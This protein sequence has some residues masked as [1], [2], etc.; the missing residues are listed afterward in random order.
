[1]N[2]KNTIGQTVIHRQHG[3]GV[4][5]EIEEYIKIDFKFKTSLFPLD[6]FEK[7]ILKFKD[8]NIQNELEKELNKEKIKDHI[9]NMY[10]DEDCSFYK[11]VELAE[12]FEENSD[13]ETANNL[14][15][16]FSLKGNYKAS[17][18]LAGK[19][20]E[21]KTV[22]YSLAKALDY[23]ELAYNQIIIYNEQDLYSSKYDVL[24]FSD[25]CANLYEMYYK[26]IG[27]KKN[28]DKAL[29]YYEELI[30]SEYGYRYYEEELEAIIEGKKISELE[31]QIKEG[32]ID[33]VVEL[34]NLYCIPRIIMLKDRPLSY[35]S[36]TKESLS[37]A[38]ELYEIAVNNNHPAAM[39]QLAR[40]Y[41]DGRYVEKDEEKAFELYKQA[42]EL[43]YINAYYFVGIGYEY[44][45]GTN[46][47]LNK[48]IEY[49]TIA[50]NKGYFY[51]TLQLATI[52]FEGE[53][54]KQDIEKAFQLIDSDVMHDKIN[55]AN[56]EDY[57][58]LKDR[59]REALNKKEEKDNPLDTAKELLDNAITYKQNETFINDRQKLNEAIEILEKLVLYNDLTAIELLSDIYYGTIT[60]TK[61]P[62]K[63][64]EL[65]NKYF[66]LDN[67]KKYKCIK[68]YYNIG[69]IY[70]N[71]EG[72][73]KDYLKSIE[74][75]NKSLSYGY[76][77]DAAVKLIE[78]YFNG[79][80][81]E[82]NIEKCIE[83][84]NQYKNSFK[85]KN[86]SKFLLE[87]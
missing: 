78:M 17:F 84:L 87:K 50:S 18:K 6:S 70:L 86:L 47:D 68:M 40:L 30:N 85:I 20:K 32:N 7:G 35:L 48:A 46:I 66:N 38:L 1:M 14:Y 77:S 49:Y 36:P 21:G 39:C 4:I 54:I 25:I 73:E 82:M 60:D 67:G 75:F 19:Y 79:I 33:A 3:E 41:K 61:N 74:M 16:Q 57:I 9:L 45:E 23:F 59:I 43:D 44:G 72:V 81:V 51:A 42:L 55:K 24:E 34:A 71:G 8:V 65:Y 2:Y 53:Y 26:G 15:V 37:R 64:L 83:I 22:L 63:A 12:F 80:G 52:Y 29:K 10:L 62:L 11:Q 58:S 5:I 76:Y 13:Y 69:L 56:Y 31:N 28:I 27:T